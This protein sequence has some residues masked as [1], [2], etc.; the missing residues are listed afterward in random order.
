M[1]NLLAVAELEL[2]LQSSALPA[3]YSYRSEEEVARDVMS[4][5]LGEPKV[6][7]EIF[8]ERKSTPP[9]E[10]TFHG[11]MVSHEEL[12]ESISEAHYLPELAGPH[13][14]ALL[15]SLVEKGCEDNQIL[16]QALDKLANLVSGSG[17]Y[18]EEENDMLLG[19][20]PVADIIDGLESLESP[21]T[22]SMTAA[23]GL[24]HLHH[25][26]DHL[27]APTTVQHAQ[28]TVDNFTVE[29]FAP[30]LNPE[31]TLETL[32]SAQEMRDTTEVNHLEYEQDAEKRLQSNGKPADVLY[33]EQVPDLHETY[34][35]NKFENTSQPQ[36]TL[37]KDEM[38]APQPLLTS[39]NN[40]NDSIK[41]IKQDI[42]SNIEMNDVQD[43][44]ESIEVKPDVKM[45]A[46]INDDF[47]VP[48]D[49][50]IVYI[51]DDREP[52]DLTVHRR[53]G[54]PHASPRRIE[55]P[56][57]PSRES[58][59]MQSP[60]PSG[61]PAIS[62]PEVFQAPP[63]KN[64]TQSILDAMFTSSSPKMYLT[65]E[66][67]ITKQQCEPLNL[68]KHRK[69]ASPTVS[70]CSEEKSNKSYGEPHEKRQ[71]RSSMDELFQITRLLAEKK[72]KD[73]KLPSKKSDQDL[74]SMSP[75]KQFQNLKANKNFN[76]PDPL[77]IPKE[78]ITAIQ[79]APGKEIPALLVERPELRYYDDLDEERERDVIVVSVDEFENMLVAKEF[80]HRQMTKLDQTSESA[81]RRSDTSATPAQTES[82]TSKPSS[83]P[84]PIPSMGALAE[85]IEAAT[86]ATLAP[87]LW[88]QYAQQQMEAVAACSQNAEFLKALNASGYGGANYSDL[89]QM[90]QNQQSRGTN[91]AGFPVMP[92]MD[93]ERMQLVIWQEMMLQKMQSQR[94][95]SSSTE[96]QM[97][98]ASAKSEFQSPYVH[99][100]NKTGS[101]YQS[102]SHSS[103]RTSPI[104]NNYSNQRSGAM[105][106][107]PFMQGMY[108]GMGAGVRPTVP[109]VPMGGLNVPYFNPSAMG[110]QRSPRTQH[111]SPTPPSPS[112]YYANSNYLA[113]LKASE[114]A[115]AAAQRA[116]HI[117]ADAVRPRISVK[118][119]DELRRRRDDAEVGSTTPLIGEAPLLPPDSS[120]PLW[121]PL[122]GK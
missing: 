71:K 101:S 111:K 114:A 68:G 19:D 90:L 97:K 6:P 40:V 9:S 45:L 56:R 120:I 103:A 94:R 110:S 86:S 67:S 83:Q 96:P 87:M 28:N 30:E 35:R 66:V 5:E 38:A 3:S 48:K 15:E 88:A 25:L 58:D 36:R 117:P 91:P 118:K 76:I 80:N 59:A 29:E 121:H 95:K 108:P 69:S 102:R 100:T 92:H 82:H 43:K 12:F 17:E 57:A 44:Q 39:D 62:S 105:G 52:R 27:P 79:N 99:S 11:D 1:D 74:L 54:T 64:K 109:T 51:E 33:T 61:I 119:V 75:L 106:Q 50:S 116:H 73:E 13:D 34:E 85:D 24:L 70:S 98:E 20:A 8:F 89:S 32:N 78:R 81:E 107:N 21:A 4:F 22:S 115:A 93:Y 37:D 16:G 18:A 72:K 2:E 60:Q 41:E 23:Q 65:S 122:F 7:D 14:E 55:I 31:C 104:T 112:A 26:G 77:L 53:M 84:K 46:K 49:L 63:T 113:G 47:E 10:D 42:E